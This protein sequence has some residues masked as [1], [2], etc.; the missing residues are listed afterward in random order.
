M[1]LT[2]TWRA[3]VYSTGAAA[4]YATTGTYTPAANSLVVAFV[5]GSLASSPTDPTGVTGH[6]VT[7]SQVT[8]SANLLPAASS[9][10]AISVWVALMGASPTT[11]ACTATWGSNRT[12]AVVD[13]F[14]IIG[15]GGSSALNAIVQQPTNIGTTGTGSVTLSAAGNSNN[16]PMSFFVHLANETS[17]GRANWTAT[18][19]GTGNFN[20]PA[21]GAIGQFRSDA[22]ET[23]ATATWSSS[24]VGWFG[25][26]LEIRALNTNTVTHSSDAF[27]K[28]V[29]YEAA[30]K[31]IT[32]IAMRRAAYW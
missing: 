25:V 30:T 2:I 7:F 5:V 9:T 15:W 8:L 21:T 14:E 4:S 23:T 12:G 16:R 18:A 22:F 6:G 10:H 19:G 3:A 1:A 17:T 29:P 26:A 20:S 11:A 31:Q 13:E 28:Q 32:K 27:I 24:T